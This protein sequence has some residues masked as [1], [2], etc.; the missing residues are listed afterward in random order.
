MPIGDWFGDEMDDV[1]LFTNQV[2]NKYGMRVA[3]GVVCTRC[4]SVSGNRRASLANV[5]SACS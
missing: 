3:S 2:L 1:R 5:F 4:L